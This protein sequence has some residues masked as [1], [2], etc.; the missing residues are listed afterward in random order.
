M[1]TYNKNNKIVNPMTQSTPV[2]PRTVPHVRARSL[3]LASMLASP[4]VWLVQPAQAQLLTNISV[5]NPKGLALAHAVTADPPGID[6][7]HFNPAGLTQISGRQTNVKL[8]VAHVELESR[9]GEPTLPTAEG[10]EVYYS[11]NEQC[12]ADYPL[13]GSST[14]DEIANQLRYV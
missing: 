11:V 13:D 9:F 1:S 8:L 7:I 14:A 4:L 2:P 6:S 10:K 5:G 12:Q 3:L